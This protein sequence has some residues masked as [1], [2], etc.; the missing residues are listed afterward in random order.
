[1]FTPTAVRAFREGAL[2]RART[3]Q[4]RGPLEQLAAA[5]PLLVKLVEGTPMVSDT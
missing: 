3:Q 2:L 4:T 1:M 5:T